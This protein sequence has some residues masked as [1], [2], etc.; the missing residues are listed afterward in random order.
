MNTIQK[1][2]VRS[3]A[4]PTILTMAL[5]ALLVGCDRS[6]QPADVTASQVN[7]DEREASEQPLGDVAEFDGYTLR[8]NVSPTEHLPDAM[9]LQYG[10]EADANVFLLNVVIL[11]NGQE[12]QPVPATGELSAYYESVTGHTT[13]IDMRE[14]EANDLVSYVGTLDTSTQRVFQFVIEAQVENTDLPLQMSF[15]AQIP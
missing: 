13:K 9:A 2:K 12:Q 3:L 5:A 15:E 6:D 1:N 4:L 10:I 8:A 14:V 7:V 11:E